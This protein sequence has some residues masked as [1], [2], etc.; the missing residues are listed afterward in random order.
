MWNCLQKLALLVLVCLGINFYSNHSFA[1]EGGGVSAGGSGWKLGS[2]FVFHDLKNSTEALN[3]AVSV[4]TINMEGEVQE[5]QVE[6]F[7]PSSELGYQE[8]KTRASVNKYLKAV[9]DQ[10]NRASWVKTNSSLKLL[11]DIFEKNSENYKPTNVYQVAIHNEGLILVQIKL[12]ELLSPLNQAALFVHETLRYLGF[13]S[14]IPI[15]T[16][17]VETLTEAL[18]NNTLSDHQIAFLDKL[19]P[20]LSLS[21]EEQHAVKSIAQFCNELVDTQTLADVSTLDESIKLLDK[22]TYLYSRSYY[23]I[24]TNE[25]RGVVNPS[26]IID[27]RKIIKSLLDRHM[28]FLYGL[29][30]PETKALTKRMELGNTILASYGA[31]TPVKI[32]IVEYAK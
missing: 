21:I 27:S 28:I 12:L 24:I 6:S 22:L 19:L 11:N 3:E 30:I 23:F 10:M 16:Y 18:I 20:R 2:K 32:R 7:K 8:L 1:R 31:G 25:D 9:M 14:K 13:A 17:E 5:L 4:D 15:E 29:W 26:N